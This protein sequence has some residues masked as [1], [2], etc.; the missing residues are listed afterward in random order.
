MENIEIKALSPQL[1]NDYF[2]FFDNVAFS[3]HEDWS[4]CYCT[5]YHFDE[6]VEKR[7]DGTG[8]DGLRNEAKLLIDRNIIQGYLAYKEKNVVGWCNCGNK[9][10]YKRLC[11]REEIWNL[12]NKDI[13]IKS[14]VCFIIA[15]G[16]R[17]KGIATQLLDRIC[18]DAKAEGFSYVEAYP[19]K[20]GK[21][22]FD[23]YHGPYKLFRNHGFNIYKEF[24]NDMIVRKHIM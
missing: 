4:W 14:V 16:M 6:S 18:C 11:A 22:C 1:V 3:D 19:L 13:K 8:K 9:M 5:Y 15:P 7:L 24:E 20:G 12:D 17:G 10:N 2:D 21:N 23:Q